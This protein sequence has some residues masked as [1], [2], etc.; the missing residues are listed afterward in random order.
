ML[1]SPPR[2]N[3][4]SSPYKAGRTSEQ[5][6]PD[7]LYEDAVRQVVTTPSGL[8]YFDLLEG[9]GAQATNGSLASIYYTSRLGGLYGVKVASTYDDP[10]APPLVL[11]VGAPD[12][13]PGVSE[14][15]VGMKV[16]GK[17]RAVVPPGIAYKNPDMKPAVKEFFARRRL[18]SVIETNRDA[19]VVFE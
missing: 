16:G 15:I 11:Q 1:H 17:R 4:Y 18:L 14:A 2:V 7:R 12:V 9:T 6:L 5:Q 10:T 8:R 13:V 3:A 19:T